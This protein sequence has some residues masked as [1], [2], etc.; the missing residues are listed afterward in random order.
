M[1]T[2]IIEGR[3]LCISTYRDIKT[4]FTVLLCFPSSGKKAVTGS[5]GLWGN[6]TLKKTLETN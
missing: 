3:F 4:K 1:D 6:K 2:R 5:E